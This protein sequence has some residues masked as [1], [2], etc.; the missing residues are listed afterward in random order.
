[1][2]SI[3]ATAGMSAGLI[4]RYFESKR[5]IILAI[6]ERQLVERRANIATLAAEP[7]LEQRI[8]ELFLA[9]RNADP[10]V[11]NAALFLEMSAE[12]SRD[13]KIAAALMHSDRV[14]GEDFLAW[15]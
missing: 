14:S 11:I 1:M 7:A 6:I 13:P 4:Y 3:A 12:A 5:E 8:K 2:A 15:M 10:G 9:W